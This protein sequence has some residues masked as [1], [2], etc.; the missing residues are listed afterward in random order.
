M[1]D[2]SHSLSTGFVHHANALT[3]TS[4]PAASL[5]QISEEVHESQAPPVALVSS[6][7][8]L[9]P[10]AS[11]SNPV[12]PLASTPTTKQKTA[13]DYANYERY[14]GIA[15]RFKENAQATKAERLAAEEAQRESE[16]RENC[17]LTV[18]VTR[19]SLVNS[20][21]S[22]EVSPIHLSPLD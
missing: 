18:T 16:E 7:V 4:P 8:P 21:P 17:L 15:Q 20:H 12:S 19:G 22:Y 5:S 6:A 3:S 2:R 9:S 11:A 1:H 13:K 10:S 14:Q